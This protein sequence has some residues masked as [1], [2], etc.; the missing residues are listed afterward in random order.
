MTLGEF[1]EWMRKRDPK[2]EREEWWWINEIRPTVERD[3]VREIAKRH[4]DV[5]RPRSG[6]RS[7]R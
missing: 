3:R 7:P 5:N 2:I 6:P 4:P 1:E